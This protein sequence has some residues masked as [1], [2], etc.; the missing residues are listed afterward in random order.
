M[1]KQTIVHYV[2]KP[3]QHVWNYVQLKNIFEIDRAY[4]ACGGRSHIP[5]AKMGRGKRQNIIINKL[6]RRAEPQAFSLFIFVMFC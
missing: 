2:W 4:G 3:P 5:R 6:I 1:Q